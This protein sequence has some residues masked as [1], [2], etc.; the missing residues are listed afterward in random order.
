[1]S[2]PARMA[3]NGLRRGVALDQLVMRDDR[4]RGRPLIR[5]IQLYLPRGQAIHH[6]LQRRLVASPTFP[7]QPLAWLLI[8]G[9]PDPEF[10]RLLLDVMP[11]LIQLQDES[12][13]RGVWL[14]IV[15]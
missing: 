4:R 7:I 1:M 2:L 13:S 14:R 10:L 3:L 12:A 15:H 5:A 11:H 9:F 8:E 6:L